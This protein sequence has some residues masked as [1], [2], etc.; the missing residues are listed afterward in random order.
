LS[1]ELIVGSSEIVVGN[2]NC[3][4]REGP[5]S[6]WIGMG[7]Y[8]LGVG[9]EDEMMRAGSSRLQY[10]YQRNAIWNVAVDGD[11]M[12]LTQFSQSVH[13]QLSTF[14]SKTHRSPQSSTIIQRATIR[15][16][17]LR[18]RRTLRFLLRQRRICSTMLAAMR[19]PGPFAKAQDVRKAV[20][21]P[22]KISSAREIPS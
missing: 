19:R 9:N 4:R 6:T 10:G 7:I 5:E 3:E 1:L 17:K 8:E 13:W 20:A 14:D 2:E 21:R 22:A 12:V 16:G 15:W 18:R 11:G